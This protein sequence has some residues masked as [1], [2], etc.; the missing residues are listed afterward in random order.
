VIS[1]PKLDRR[2]FLALLRAAKDRTRTTARRDYFLIYL[3]GRT[4]LRASELLALRVADLSLD[5]DPPFLWVLTLKQ[6]RRQRDQVLL[7]AR[8]ARRART[9]LSRVLPRLLG[10]MKPTPTDPMFPAPVMGARAPRAMSLRNVSRIFAVYAGRARLRPGV[11]FH[12][13][14]H[15]RAWTLQTAS[16]GDL[17]FT[18]QQLRHRFISSTQRYLGVTP[19]Q[20][21][22]YLR[23]LDRRG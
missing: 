10:G 5:T 11:T 6:R 16:H 4:G 23:A 3:A 17:E 19:E 7:E 1:R 9:Y 2:G 15:F 12:A 8:T 13:L 14:R 20:E 21:A 22:R 18:R